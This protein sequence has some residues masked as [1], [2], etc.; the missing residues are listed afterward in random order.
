M[1]CNAESGAG[2]NVTEYA[3]GQVSFHSYPVGCMYDVTM[4]EDY[5]IFAK[6]NF[7]VVL[8]VILTYISV[9]Y[10]DPVIHSE[11]VEN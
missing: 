7:F 5:F 2:K 11:F 9:K 4:S 1:Y 8:I 10:F 6:A 3:I